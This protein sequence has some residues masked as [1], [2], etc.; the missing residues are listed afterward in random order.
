MNYAATAKRTVALDVLAQSYEQERLK[1]PVEEIEELRMK[2]GVE[3]S[4]VTDLQAKNTELYQENQ[5]LGSKADHLDTKF[6][7][8][9]ARVEELE[10]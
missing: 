6:Q 9:E 3:S 1:R 2:L 8:A 7:G 4:K 10:Q 5:K